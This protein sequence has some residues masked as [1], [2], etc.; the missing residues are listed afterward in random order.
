MTLSLSKTLKSKFFYLII[1]FSLSLAIVLKNLIRGDF[2]NNYI[3]FKYNFIHL[4]AQKNLFLA[5]PQRYFDLNH[6]GP[7]FG[8]IIA[9]F[10]VF[11]D[12]IGVLLWVAFNCWILYV[13]VFQLPLSEIQKLMIL[14]IC[15]HELMTSSAS[16]Q[17]NPLITAL[18]IL[19]FCFITKGK[20]FWATMMIILGTLIK[21]YGIVGI[22]FYLFSKNKSMFRRSLI[23]WTLILL[24]LPALVSSPQFIIQTYHDW[25]F[26]LINKNLA[27]ATSIMQNISVMGMIERIFSVSISNLWIIIPALTIYFLPLVRYKLYQNQRFQLLILSSTLIFTVIFSSAAESPTYIIAFLG[28][29]IWFVTLPKPISKFNIGLFI[30]ALLLTSLSPSDLFPKYIRINY[31]IPYGL[32]ALPC[33]LIWLK[34]I[35]ETMQPKVF[36]QAQSDKNL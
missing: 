23:F 24:L 7:L 13:A 33:F 32:K 3:I 36:F 27:N 1:W 25:Y 29:A 34:I 4:I 5:Y 26:D 28:V 9:P 19:S 22:V 6:Y 30:F 35:K 10:T 18:I 17:S 15:S 16:V 20:D 8:L 12:Q 14:L 11:P 31:I 21:L 2:P